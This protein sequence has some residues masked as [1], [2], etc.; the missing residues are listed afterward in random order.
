[1]KK[2]HLSQNNIQTQYK[3]ETLVKEVYNIILLLNVVGTKP[4]LMGRWGRWKD[5]SP[6][7]FCPFFSEE[8]FPA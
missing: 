6:G 2:K 3:M 8:R 4:D 5:G 7:C 1:M